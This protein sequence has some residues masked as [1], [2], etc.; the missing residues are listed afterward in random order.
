MEVKTT[1][2][3]KVQIECKHPTEGN[4]EVLWI[5]KDKVP[6]Q[7]ESKKRR[8]F[9]NRKKGKRSAENCKQGENERKVIS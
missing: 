7:K 9:E 8:T 2:K 5:L 4:G 6:D 1:Y 3:I